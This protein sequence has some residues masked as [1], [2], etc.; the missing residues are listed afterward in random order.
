MR[1]LITGTIVLEGPEILLTTG[2]T[3]LGGG[4]REAGGAREV[5]NKRRNS[6]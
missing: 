3:M 6:A 4:G 1:L 5:G 2:E